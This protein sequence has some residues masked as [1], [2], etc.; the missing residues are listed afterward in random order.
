[1]YVRMPPSL[2][3]IYFEER[4]GYAHFLLAFIVIVLHPCG[5]SNNGKFYVRCRFPL[6]V[7]VLLPLCE[8]EL[9]RLSK[10]LQQAAFSSRDKQAAESP[11]DMMPSDGDKSDDSDADLSLSLKY[12]EKSSASFISNFK[13][14]R[15]RKRSQ[16]DDRN[17]KKQRKNSASSDNF[18]QKRGQ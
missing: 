2:P 9:S 14:M 17:A 13:S 1:M 3:G 4:P 8:T 12:F 10:L 11:G 6:S 15:K 16:K 7:K 5:C 18:R